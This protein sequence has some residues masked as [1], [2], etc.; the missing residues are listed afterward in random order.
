MR[1]SIFT[2]ALLAI[3]SLALTSAP[4]SASVAVSKDPI[5][6]IGSANIHIVI[7]N[8]VRFERYHY[9]PRYDVYFSYSRNRY[10]WQDRGK[11]RNG[12]HLPRHLNHAYYERYIVIEARQ[13]RPWTYQDDRRYDDRR[14]DD[15]RYDNRRYD[16]RRYDDRRYD[17]RRNNDWD[18]RRDDRRDDRRGDRRNDDRRDDNRND[19]RRGN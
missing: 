14:Y 8:G 6:R 19:R 12:R 2:L 1:H 16:D 7:R 11:W 4:A 18:N 9:Y 3:F 17:D 15:R 13:D 10:Y 5:I